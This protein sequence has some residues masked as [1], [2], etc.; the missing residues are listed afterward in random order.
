M[1][2]KFRQ[3]NSPFHFENNFFVLVWFSN[4][5]KYFITPIKP[6]NTIQARIW[7]IIS[8]NPGIGTGF[9]IPVTK[10]METTADAGPAEDPKRPFKRPGDGLKMHIVLAIA[11][12]IVVT[13][14]WAMMH[15]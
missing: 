3:A 13:T 8:N 10:I 14:I 15:V 4:E 5:V 6:A 7:G 11:Y 12:A 2:I 9:S 1:T